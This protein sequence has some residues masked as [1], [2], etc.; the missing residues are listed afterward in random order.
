MG[1]RLIERNSRRVVLTEAGT[2]FLGY[3]RRILHETKDA[4][5]AAQRRARGETGT[6]RIGFIGTLSYDLLPRLLQAYHALYPDVDLVLKEL[7]PTQQR[8]EILAERLDCGFMGFSAENQDPEL[9]MVTVASEPLVAALP[10]SHPLADQK[11]VALSKLKEDP[12]YLTAR[13]NAPAFNPW[14]IDLCRKAGFEPQIKREMDRAATVLSYVA[15]GFGISIFPAPLA[16]LA[17]LVFV[18]SRSK[19]RSR[20]TNTNSRGLEGTSPAP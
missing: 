4:V 17:S 5:D 14:V 15:A 9:E 1:V 7:G 13:T 18:F 10:V 16:V 2:L 8:N 20:F 6:L 11:A 3:V 12:I 19:E